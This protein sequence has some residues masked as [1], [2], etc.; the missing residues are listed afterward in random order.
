MR[1]MTSIAA[2]ALVLSLPC[3]PTVAAQESTAHGLTVTRDAAT[4][5]LRAPTTAELQA[6][7]AQTQATAGR[8][9]QPVFD[10]LPDGRSRAFLGESGLVYSVVTRG[11]D[12]KIDQQ[13]VHGAHAAEHI[14]NMATPQPA[15]PSATEESHH[16][17]R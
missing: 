11:A 16:G 15:A 7:S 10:T 12:G 5:K 8:P 6:L 1:T 9:A 13:C 3:L 2:S 14:V 17:H 4:G